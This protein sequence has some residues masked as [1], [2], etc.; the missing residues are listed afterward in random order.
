[1]KKDKKLGKAQWRK[2]RNKA[3]WGR[4]KS[5][6]NEKRDQKKQFRKSVKAYERTQD[7]FPEAT[8]SKPR[9]SQMEKAERIQKLRQENVNLVKKIAALKAQLASVGVA[10]A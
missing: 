7:K 1:M 3:L 9:S 5:E 4:K 10:I 6:R 2:A 8:K